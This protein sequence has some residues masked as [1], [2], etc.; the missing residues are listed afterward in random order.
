MIYADDKFERPIGA[1]FDVG[2]RRVGGQINLRR[3]NLFDSNVVSIADDKFVAIREGGSL[4][5]SS[6][7]G[8]VSLLGCVQGG[9]LTTTSWGDFAIH[10]GDVAFRYALFGKRHVADDERC[11]QGIEFTLEGTESSV[12]THN[13]FQ[14][15]G[16]IDDPD[17][18][19]L[20]AIR[21][22]R[23][24]Y[25]QGEFVRGSAM[26]SY[27]TGA[28]ELLPR[29]KTVLGTLSVRRSMRVDLSGRSMED[30]PRISIDFDGEPT[31]L[32]S[33]WEKMREVRQFFA[34]MMGYA[35]EWKDVM[36][37]TFELDEEE[38]RR[39]PDGDLEAFG[40]NEWNEIPDSAKRCGTLIDA[41]RHPDHFVEVMTKWLERNEDARRKTA[42]TRFFGCIRG[43]SE[44]VIDDAVV[45]AANTFDLLPTGDKPEV[46]P[47]PDD[48]L[49]ALKDARQRVR[50]AMNSSP[51]RAD[52]LNALGRIGANKRLRDV[53]EH[54]AIIVQDHFGRD[55]LDDLAALIRLAVQ[56][57]NYYTHGPNEGNPSDV[58]FA[59]F[60]A[61]HFLTETL[62]FIYGASE[63]LLCGWESAKSARTEWHPIGGYV[64]SY[65]YRRSVVVE[66]AE[67]TR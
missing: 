48:V 32:E 4:H 64:S 47:L 21:R 6:E 61:V 23:P 29:F 36:V 10:H 25:L 16:H 9:M 49:D 39:D 11:V 46:V 59:D 54:R 19:I 38:S 30:T 60:Q 3:G 51:E 1:L 20:D 53:V 62:E 55:R 50:A 34:W 24:D 14:R 2:D 31:T 58:D 22:K 13:K 66:P 65:D 56:C 41:S 33:A 12:F 7:A 57:R 42:N 37:S 18:E 52:I 15:F 8:R 45:S 43:M 63:L 67:A 40:P 44:R 5:G 26:V 35:P 27:F 28:W 17:D